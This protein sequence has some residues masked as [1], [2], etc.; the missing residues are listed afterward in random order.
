MQ[1][2]S[3][4]NLYFGDLHSHCNVGYGHGSLRDAYE[5]AQLQLDFVAVTPHAYW[6]DM[7]VEDQSLTDLVA[8]H[9]GGFQRTREAWNEVREAADAATIPGQF[10]AFLAYEWHSN[11]YGDHNVYF[12]DG[13]GD[14]FRSDSL[15]D[16]RQE[17]RNLRTRGGDAFLI[18]HH[19]GY[20]SG[21]RGINWEQYSAELS[22][23][24]EAMSM[25]GCAES[26]EAPYPYY[27]TMGPRNWKSTYQYGLSRGNLVGLIGSTDHHSAHP[28]SYGHGGLAVWADDLTRES[29]FEAIKARRCYAITGDK[30]ALAFAVN[31][32]SMG[33]VAPA[34]PDRS[35]DV[36][37]EAGSS[38]DYVE[39][40]HNNE[41][42]HRS[43]GIKARV[44]A[45][46]HSDLFKT[47]FEVGW[48]EVGK[49]VDW[50][51]DLSVVGG[52]LTDVQPRF[53]GHS[54]VAPQASDEPTYQF[55]RWDRYEPSGV[56][57]NTR[58]WGNVN[59]STPGMQGVGLE[60]RGDDST[61]ISAVVNGHISEIPLATLREGPH[62]GYLGGFLSPAFAFSRAVPTAEFSQKLSF[63]HEARTGI[64]DWYYVRVRQHNGQWAWSSPVWIEA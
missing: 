32:V 7:P 56:R 23:V 14:I 59:S 43:N 21:T 53:R 31:D 28:G 30:I 13:L 3:A 55:S 16:L 27:H 45:H 1:P 62:T 51:V 58:T 42:I 9:R 34:S 52:E 41:V 12:R 54:I 39:V 50:A 26:A 11:T 10:A 8:Y 36:E 5:N 29:I 2:N 19:I 57:F 17:V 48:G 22:P 18:P 25:H 44:D 37:V 15:E 24:A 35:V 61:V 38:I 60:I 6:H 46:G 4:R 49:N 33:G 40:L 20:R 64:R 47:H 63:D